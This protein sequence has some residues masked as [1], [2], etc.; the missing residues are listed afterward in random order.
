MRVA[1]TLP[2]TKPPTINPAP[3]GAKNVLFIISDDMR[4]SIGAYGL[5]Q[6][7]SPNLDKLAR[8]GILFTRAHIQFSYCAPSRNSFMSGRRPDANKVYNFNTNFREQGIGDQWV[9]LPEH[10]K[11]NGYLTTGTG[12]LYHPGVPPN[13]DQPRSWSPIGPG[14]ASWPYLESGVVNASDVKDHPP[15]PNLYGHGAARELK[16]DTFLLDQTVKNIAVSR[17]TAAI[18]NW[19]AT[20]QPFF[21]GMGTHRPVSHCSLSSFPTCVP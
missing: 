12:K 3:K 20:G 19:K 8:D 2:P 14:N 5:P 21:V 18:V 16:P 11:R 17:L 13:F 10:F 4:P 9:A 1:P 6:A 15:Y 7:V